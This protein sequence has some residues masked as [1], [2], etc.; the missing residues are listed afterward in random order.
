MLQVDQRRRSYGRS[1]GEGSAGSQF[2]SS[3]FEGRFLL[4]HL[5]FCIETCWGRSSCESCF[6]NDKAG[7][8]QVFDVEVI[9]DLVRR[10]RCHVLEDGDF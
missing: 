8:Q 3:N 6:Y 5:L 7:Y 10:G 2:W 4:A 1:S 9:V